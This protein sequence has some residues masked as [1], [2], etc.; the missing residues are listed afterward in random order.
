MISNCTVLTRAKSAGENA[1]RLHPHKPIAGWFPPWHFGNKKQLKFLRTTNRGRRRNPQQE[2]RHELAQK[3]VTTNS[4]KELGISKERST[5]TA[6]I[7][8]NPKRGAQEAKKKPDRILQN[9]VKP[10]NEGDHHKIWKQISFHVRD[11]WVHWWAHHF[12][13]PLGCREMKI[14]TKKSTLNQDMEF[15]RTMSKPQNNRWRTQ[16]SKPK[17]NLFI[18][19][20]N[21]LIDEFTTPMPPTNVVYWKFKQITSTAKQ[22]NRVEFYNTMSKPRNKRSWTPNSNSKISPH[23]WA[24]RITLVDELATPTLPTDVANWNPIKNINIEANTTD[25]MK[26]YNTVSKPRKN[27]DEPKLR[28]QN[29]SPVCEHW[30]LHSLMSSPLRNFPTMP[31][32]VLHRNNIHQSINNRLCRTYTPPCP[33]LPAGAL[34]DP[35]SVR[36]TIFLRLTVPESFVGSCQFATSLANW[37]TTLATLQ[38]E[39]GIF[40]GPNRVSTHSSGQKDRDSWRKVRGRLYDSSLTHKV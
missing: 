6:N 38:Q 29:F 15:S 7:P 26:F 37:Q 23:V 25:D 9:H 3:K 17:K 24:L 33:H 31:W 19:V 36:L 13:F 22:R 40:G 2:R 10:Q 18:C 12:K 1:K 35:N 16:N 28:Y 39:I 20:R 21:T 11:D 34:W 4:E 32:I 5:K 8:G 27:G 30:G 14:Q